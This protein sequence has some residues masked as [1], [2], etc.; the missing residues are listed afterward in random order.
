MVSSMASSMHISLALVA[1][2]GQLL[3]PDATLSLVIY[4]L[5]GVQ[6]RQTDM[7][8][9]AAPLIAASVVADLAWLFLFGPLA[10]FLPGVPTDAPA[11]PS[12]EIEPLAALAP[13][14]RLAYVAV[15]LALKLALLLPQQP[16]L[17]AYAA[18]SEETAA[19]RDAQDDVAF[20]GPAGG[21][22]KSV[23]SFGGVAN[24]AKAAK[25]LK[26]NGAAGRDEARNCA[27]RLIMLV[28][29]ALLVASFWSCICRPDAGAM[30][31]LL[32]L[33]ALHES[34]LY[35][36]RVAAGATL[37]TLA[38]DWVWLRFQ[39][40]PGHAVSG[41]VG[42]LCS[43]TG[44][45]ALLGGQPLQLQL[46]VV[47]TLVTLPL[48]LLLLLLLLH[49]VCLPHVAEK[50]REFRFGTPEETALDSSLRPSPSSSSVSL[51]LA[52]SPAVPETRA[53]RRR[54]ERVKEGQLTEAKRVVTLCFIGLLLAAAIGSMGLLSGMSAM[55]PF[56]LTMLA[57][58][59]CLRHSKVCMSQPLWVASVRVRQIYL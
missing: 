5:V 40:F 41:L 33:T 15:G 4:L 42:S 3:R 22:A 58:Y 47:S 29:M 49:L 57:A 44:L 11:A 23:L 20:R 25:A 56:V 17:R 16:L 53:A 37:V 36:S 46:A 45:A 48:K 8:E 50:K 27:S 24:I 6:S 38:I 14:G 59:G 54:L 2:F 21:A 39:A 52:D 10:P 55:E 28:G 19:H 34:R 7:L 12:C 32:V 30:L 31:G 18:L 1:T 9:P 26:R 51:D 13:M 35:F 43:A